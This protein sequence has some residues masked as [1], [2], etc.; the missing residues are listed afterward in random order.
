MVSQKLKLQAILISTDTSPPTIIIVF[1]FLVILS[2]RA[3]S[4]AKSTGKFKALTGKRKSIPD[5]DPNKRQKG[6]THDAIPN[7]IT[8]PSR[9]KNGAGAVP[10]KNLLL[11]L[12]GPIPKVPENAYI[13]SNAWK[14]FGQVKVRSAPVTANCS[15]VSKIFIMQHA[16]SG[17]AIPRGIVWVQRIMPTSCWRSWVRNSIKIG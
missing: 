15:S 5:D 16:F 8:S 1:R 13:N 12:N 11:K 7:I 9:P 3:M 2:D 14:L 6:D 17:L 4:A 10:R